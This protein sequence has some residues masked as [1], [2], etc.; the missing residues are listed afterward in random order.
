MAEAAKHIYKLPSVPK[1]VL[2]YREP[3]D[4]AQLLDGLTL[5]KLNEIFK[6]VMRR[7]EDKLDPIRS[8]FGKIQQEEVSLPDK[9]TEVEEYALCHSRFS[10]RNLLKRQASK[11]QVIVTF[12]AILE[13][14]KMGKILIRQEQI[15]GEIEIESRMERG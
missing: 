11:V 13:L 7:Q 6:S 10:F 12:L 8:K 15:F 3:V 2:S 5:E 14:M 4:T 9:M 1:E